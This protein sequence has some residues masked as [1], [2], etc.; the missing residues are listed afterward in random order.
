MELLVFVSV[1]D[2]NTSEKRVVSIFILVSLFYMY[3]NLN[4]KFLMMHVD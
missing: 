3:E 4:Y 1:S 2:S